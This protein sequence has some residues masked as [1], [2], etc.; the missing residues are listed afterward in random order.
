MQP[1]EQEQAFER[2]V[3]VLA[4]GPDYLIDITLVEA[5]VWQG[6]VIDSGF[7]A[8]IQQVLDKAVLEQANNPA[9]SA[10]KSMGENG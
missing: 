5:I 2:L 1:D 7:G 8:E 10:P 9:M 3:E 6:E 4:E